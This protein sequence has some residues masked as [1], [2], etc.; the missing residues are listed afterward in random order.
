MKLFA[1]HPKV[2]SQDSK[3]STWSSLNSSFARTCY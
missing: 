2:Q 3:S 1:A